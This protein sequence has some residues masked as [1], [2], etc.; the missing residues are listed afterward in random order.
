MPP[1]TSFRLSRCWTLSVVKTSMPAA[2]SSSTS[3]QRL[4]WRE[5]GDV[6]VRELVDEHQRRAARERGVEIELVSVRPSC[7]A[8]FARGRTSRPV[9]QRLG[10]RAAVRL[11]A[12]RRR[13]PAPRVAARA[14]RVSIAYVLPT[15]ADAPK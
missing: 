2:S 1:T 10:F 15:P 12:R 14:P 3:C 11:D 7:Q 4:G 13:R 6:G 5:P 9:Q 8:I